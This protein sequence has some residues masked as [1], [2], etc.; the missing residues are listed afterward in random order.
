MKKLIL[1]VLT[2]L[3]FVIA[4]TG[5]ITTEI[6]PAIEYQ[7]HSGEQVAAVGGDFNLNAG[8][9]LELYTGYRIGRTER[10]R[11]HQEFRIGA[12][13]NLEYWDKL[14]FTG[15][16]EYLQ[17][18]YVHSVEGRKNSFWQDS[19]RYLAGF[20][21]IGDRYTIQVLGYLQPDEVGFTLRFNYRII[22]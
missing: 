17:R 3:S 8:N 18:Y 19:F 10:K 7:H 11:L 6:H 13:G 1:I 4:A 5:Q 22:I 9:V 20:K 21:W 12:V 16:F 15:G 2:L 14:H